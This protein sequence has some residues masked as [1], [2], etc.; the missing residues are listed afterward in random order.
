M[1]VLR[2]HTRSVIFRKDATQL[3]GLVDNLVRFYGSRTGLNRQ[4][5]VFRF[6]DNEEHMCEWG[7]IGGPGD[8]EIWQGREHDLLCIDEATQVSQAVFEYV[9][10]WL[11]TVDPDQRCRIILTFNPPGGPDDES[12]GSGRWVIDYFAPWIDERHP[13]PAKYGEL[14][15]FGPDPET[16][17][18]TERP[19]GDPYELTQIGPDGE[20]HTSMFTPESRTFIHARVWDNPHLRNTQ[21]ERNLMMQSNQVLRRKFLFGDFRSGIVDGEWQVIPTAH[22]DEAMDRWEEMERSGATGR[23]QPMTALG[24][25][26]ARGGNNWTV[27]APRHGFWWDRLQ[28]HP[29]T[30]TRDGPTVSALCIKTVR[31]G[32]EIG[33]DAIGVGSSPHDFLK[34]AGANVVAIIGGSTEYLPKIDPV[35]E[36][37]NLRSL[38][39]WLMRLILDPA[40]Q[41]EPA[42]P[43][44]NRLRSE[45]IAHNYDVNT[46]KIRVE[47][48]RDIKKR[49]RFSPDDSDAVIYTLRNVLTNTPGGERLDGRIKV[50]VQKLKRELYGN[51]TRHRGGIMALPDAEWMGR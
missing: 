11:R 24:C 10:T 48:K 44:D 34:K 33:I 13:N 4:A 38:L 15:Y 19:N 29:G 9:K 22:V 35:M 2:A 41:L 12:G 36:C 6:A 43:K 21:Y 26:V 30:E 50:D 16:L 1:L 51:Q 17:E 14:R 45:L 39:Y 46:G 18:V 5:N 8:A 3:R 32:A 37:V 27:L 40:N 49:L 25:D 23:R 7:G 42:L 20:A 31:D 47:E 28:R